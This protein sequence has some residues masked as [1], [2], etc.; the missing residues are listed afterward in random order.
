M[1][2]EREIGTIFMAEEKIEREM[3]PIFIDEEH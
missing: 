2:E 1:E 3:G